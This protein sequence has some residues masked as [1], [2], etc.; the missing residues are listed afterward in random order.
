MNCI[1]YIN[2]QSLIDKANQLPDAGG[3]SGGSV[4]TCTIQFDY[5]DFIYNQPGT[6]YYTKPDLSFGEAT[7]QASQE[8]IVP[9]TSVTVL[10]NSVV[11]LAGGVFQDDEFKTGT[12]EEFGTSYGGDCE[13]L[14]ESH[15]GGCAFYVTGDC[16]ISGSN[17]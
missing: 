15:I 4:E 5:F 8:E 2:L 7:Y 17:G 11:V 16:Y 3:G 14:I 13:V 1:E 9:P 10:K 6:L 12:A